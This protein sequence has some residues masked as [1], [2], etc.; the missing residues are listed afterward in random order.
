MFMLGGRD[1]EE[2]EYQREAKRMGAD[3][4]YANGSTLNVVQPSF[5]ILTSG[6]LTYPSNRPIAAVHMNKSGGKLMVCGSVNMFTDD[7]FESEDNQKIMDFI[8]K[9]FLTE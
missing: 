7:Y 2:E 8:L 5:P 1:D 9:F 4:V 6:P 3:F